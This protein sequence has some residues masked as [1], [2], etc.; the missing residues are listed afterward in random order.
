MNAENMEFPNQKFNVIVLNFILS[1]VEHPEKA[2]GRSLHLLAPNGPILVF[3][4]FID[5][6]RK[7][8]MIRRLLNTHIG[9]RNGYYP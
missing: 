8:N 9:Y 1:V 3:D 7:P 2:L 5:S 6:N 4:K